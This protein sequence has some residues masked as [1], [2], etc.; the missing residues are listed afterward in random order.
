MKN[1]KGEFS[2]PN[3]MRSINASSED[4]DTMK[5]KRFSGFIHENWLTL[6]KGNSKAP[7][8][9]AITLRCRGG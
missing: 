6:V 4:V 2:C 5:C 1:M 3:K 8:S 7:F 9:I